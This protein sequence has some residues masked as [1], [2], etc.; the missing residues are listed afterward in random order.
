MVVG[1]RQTFFLN[2][3]IIAF[4]LLLYPNTDSNTDPHRLQGR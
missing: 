4:G 1:W 3:L 2:D